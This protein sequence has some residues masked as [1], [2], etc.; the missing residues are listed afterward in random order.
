MLG[1]RFAGRWRFDEDA[2]VVRAEAFGESLPGLRVLQRCELLF[3]FQ[4]AA[5][6]QRVE[7][8]RKSFAKFSTEN[9]VV[10]QKWFGQFGLRGFGHLD[11]DP[12]SAVE[13]WAAAGNESVYVRMMLQPLIP[14]VQDQQRGGADA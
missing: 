14:G 1:S 2:P 13:R 4:F 12:A 10:N 9:F 5:S 7:P 6:V 8:V 11:I 3:Q